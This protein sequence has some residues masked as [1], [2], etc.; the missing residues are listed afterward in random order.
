MAFNGKYEMKQDGINEIISERG[1]IFLA[2]REVRWSES[3]PFKLDLRHYKSDEEGDKTLKGVSFTDDDADEIVDVLIKNGYGDND[4]IAGTIV[5][6]RPALARTIKSMD[7]SEEDVKQDARQR[8]FSRRAAEDE[9]SDDE[10]YFPSTS[11][12]ITY[13]VTYYRPE[14]L[15][16]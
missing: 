15:L 8:L 14:E 2:L 4:Q 6:E 11:D 9:E 10:G 12:D 5:S 3:K 16:E 7:I 13:D 1:D